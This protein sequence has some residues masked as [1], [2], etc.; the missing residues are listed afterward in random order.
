MAG[1]T[2]IWKHQPVGMIDAAPLRPDLLGSMTSK[3]VVE[4]ALLI[5][6]RRYP[7]GELFHIEGEPGD[8]LTVPGAAN[9]LHLAQGMKAGTLVVRG[10]AG[11]LAGMEITGGRI[12]IEGSAGASLGASMLG[13]RIEVQGDTGENTGGPSPNWTEGMTQG[14]I[15]IAGRAGPRCGLRQRGGLI[16][17]NSVAEY[18]GYH[19]LAGTIVIRHGP[20]AHAGLGLRRGTIVYLDPATPVTWTPT[21]LPDC[22][23]HPVFLKVL[24][25]YLPQLGF[26]VPAGVRHG[27]FR[28]YSGDRL[29]LGKGEVLHLLA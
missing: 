26:S 10:D 27:R 4:T 23:D 18:V 22:D 15:L 13:G 7:L 11:S 8:T 3:Q 29:V 28:R 17:A 24:L 9:Y 5:G 2:L 21:Y 1:Y 14:E 12:V 20:I 25:G 19:M 6:R 16:A